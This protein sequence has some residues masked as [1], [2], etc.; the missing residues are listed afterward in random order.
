VPS[1]MN[2]GKF[3]AFPLPRVSI[4]TGY[5]EWSGQEGMSLRAYIA[6]HALAGLLA[7]PDVHGRPEWFVH[8][9]VVYADALL[10]ELAKEPT[11]G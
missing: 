7:A 2:K 10:A 8:S 6:T 1:K 9:A 4:P 5:V 3:P 11:D